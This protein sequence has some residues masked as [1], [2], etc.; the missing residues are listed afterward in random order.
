MWNDMKHKVKFEFYHEDIVLNTA[1]PVSKWIDNVHSTII[2][3][4]H[5]FNYDPVAPFV[6]LKHRIHSKELLLNK[7][8]SY[9]PDATIIMVDEL[10]KI[11]PTWH[12][13]GDWNGV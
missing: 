10:N 7:L 5:I 11:R 6:P 2:H 1:L 12:M 13:N 8:K 3:L 9:I 4:S